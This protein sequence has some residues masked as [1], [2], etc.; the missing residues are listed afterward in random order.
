VQPTVSLNGQTFGLSFRR[1]ADNGRV[2]IDLVDDEG[3]YARATSNL[4]EVTLAPDEV[5]IKDWSENA[6][7]TEALVAAGV[8]ED[9]GRRVNAGYV[10]GTVCRLLI[11]PTEDKP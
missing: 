10:Q 4:P 2:V 9:T 5:I 11:A 6:G 3:V 1:Y 7:M 8:V